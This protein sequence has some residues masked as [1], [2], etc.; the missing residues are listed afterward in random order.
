MSLEGVIVTDGNERSALAVTRSLGQRGIPVYVGAEAATSL[1]GVSRYCAGSFVYPSPWTHPQ[2]Y[3]SC[4]LEQAKRF[5]ARLIFPMTDVAVELIGEHKERVG[6]DVMMPIPSLSQYRA[7]SDKYQL[8]AWAEKEGIPIPKTFFVE[9]GQLESVINRIQQW[10]VVVKPG[11]SLVKDGVL[12]KKTSVRYAQNPEELRS[13]YKELWY[14]KWPSLLQERIVGR[15]EGVF[16]LFADGQPK[17]LFAHRRLREK[18]PSGGVSVFRESIPLPTPMADYAVRV[19]QSAHWHGVAMIEFKVDQVSQVP[20]LM[21]VNGRFWGSLQLAIDAGVDFPWLLYQLATTA[22]VPSVASSYREG[23]R[24]RWWLGDLDHMLIR[25]RKSDAALSLP[26]GAPSRR[27]TFKSF[28]S[29]LDPATQPEIFRLHDLRPGLLELWMYGRDIVL[30][31]GWGWSQRL[32]PFR[33]VVMRGLWAIA[34]KCGLHRLRVA[35]ALPGRIQSILF[36][37]KGNICRSPFAAEYVREK[38]QHRDSAM[39]VTSAGL[40]TNAGELANQMAQATSVRYGI[41]LSQHRT[42]VLSGEMVA[43]ADLIVVMERHHCHMLFESF[44]EARPKTLLLGLFSNESAIDIHDPYGRPQEAFSRCY[45]II[46]DACDRLLSKIEGK[47]Q[48]DS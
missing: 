16:G 23:V 13:L 29:V 30:R 42:R 33:R 4:V 48:P 39:T 19:L 25:V 3:V 26:P 41:D 5:R 47:A 28:F 21:E 44:P 2:E 43:Q 8:T 24:S 6:A 14:L 9:R 17:V 10:P 31:G 46:R 12:W 37:C 18:P 11:R 20:Y 38:L 27:D 15:G 1:A 32:A 7:L 35:N 22:R 36:L 34:M 45:S 40:D